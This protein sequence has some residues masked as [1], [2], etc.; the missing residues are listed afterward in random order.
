[1]SERQF[2]FVA[3]LLSGAITPPG[4]SSS[5]N[6]PL[7]PPDAPE[8]GLNQIFLGPNGLRAGWRLL[9]FAAI[10]AVFIEGL[11][12]GG[13]LLSHGHPS[14]QGFSA[15]GIIIGEAVAFVLFL[16]ASWIMAKME[17]RTLGDYGLPLRKAFQKEFWQ[18]AIVGFIALTV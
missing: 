1:M 12:Y 15:T 18:G 10:M 16:M 11:R 5:G 8:S 14:Q 13:K 2:G 17:G 3:P 9:I 4:I 7:P 6:A